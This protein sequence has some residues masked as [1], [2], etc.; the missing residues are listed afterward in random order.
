MHQLQSTCDYCSVHV[1]K[2]QKRSNTMLRSVFSM[3]L[4]QLM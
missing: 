4:A 1:I 2:Q 3:Q